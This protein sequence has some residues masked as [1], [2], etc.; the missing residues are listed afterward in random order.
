MSLLIKVIM[1]HTSDLL[2][3]LLIAKKDGTYYNT[4]KELLD[5]YLL[6]IDEIGFK[7][8]DTN[9]VDEFF[10]INKKKV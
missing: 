4:L 6:I 8:I 5:V 9:A 10:E 3:K 7:R 2:N 1:I